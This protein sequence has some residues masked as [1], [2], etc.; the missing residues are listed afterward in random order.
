MDRGTEGRASSRSCPAARSHLRH[1][2]LPARCPPAWHLLI[3]VGPHSSFRPWFLLFQG[4]VSLSPV[5]SVI[6][7]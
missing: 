7:S 6:R 4:E 2:L 5:V 3:P 1:P